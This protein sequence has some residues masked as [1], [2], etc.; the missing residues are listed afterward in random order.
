[1]RRLAPRGLVVARQCHEGLGTLVLV[2]L[3]V[4]FVAVVQVVQHVFMAQV[5]DQAS[6]AI[7]GRAAREVAV[8]AINETRSLIADRFNTPG[9]TEYALARRIRTVT[10]VEEPIAIAST[11]LQ[12]TARLIKDQYQ[13]SC[14]LVDVSSTLTVKGPLFFTPAEQEAIF[15]IQA[16][17][18][19]KVSPTVERR[20]WKRWGLK[21]TFLG[22]AGP[23][24]SVLG[25]IRSPER[26]LR[27]RVDA[28]KTVDTFL[29]GDLR[30]VVTDLRRLLVDTD[31]KIAAE[32]SAEVRAVLLQIRASYAQLVETPNGGS[33]G[34]RLTS[35]AVRH[36]ALRPLPLDPKRMMFVNAAGSLDLSEFNLQADLVALLPVHTARRSAALALGQQV[37]SATSADD[38]VLGLH[39][40]FCRSMEEYTQ[41]L[42]QFIS[43]YLRFRETFFLLT[44]DDAAFS[45]HAVAF[46]LLDPRTR[47]PTP[48]HFPGFDSRTTV[49]LDSPRLTP[50]PEFALAAALERL[51]GPGGFRGVIVIDNQ[52]RPL[53]LTGVMKGQFTLAVLGPL[54][55]E[56]LTVRDPARDMVTVVHCVNPDTELTLTG[57]VQATVVAQGARLHVTAGARITGSLLLAD[58][59]DSTR[60]DSSSGGS[61]RISPCLLLRG[62]TADSLRHVTLAPW[63]RSTGSVRDL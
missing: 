47:W 59:D 39:Q 34:A 24:Q 52:G 33:I 61:D 49:I 48:A 43:R 30:G 25:L 63:V 60:I 26:V 23:L 9:R 17:V 16:S 36:A 10:N 35:L 14:T 6:N 40:Q 19:S 45:G 31:A 22:P 51:G 3:L 21:T 44:A 28:P 38:S 32:S 15:T 50:S 5:T 58:V 7:L 53:R 8:S 27:G 37:R 57:N 18:R 13:D 4:G 46:H 12:A 54:T 29:N 56:N 11:E 2:L 42:E 1:M 62:A 20:L 55:I 41:L